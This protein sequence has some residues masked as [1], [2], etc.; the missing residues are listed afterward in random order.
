MPSQFVLELA[1]ARSALGFGEAG[2]PGKHQDGCRVV[3]R[4]GRALAT[5]V[6]NAGTN[7]GAYLTALFGPGSLNHLG[8]RWAFVNNWRRLGFAW[9]IL[10]LLFVPVSGR[11][12]RDARSRARLYPKRSSTRSWANPVVAA[13]F[14]TGK[15]GRSLAENSDRSDNGGSICFGSLIFSSGSTACGSWQIGVP[16]WL[17]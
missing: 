16:I 11:A 3:P 1:I 14:R 15:P 2:V 17:I 8:W 12:P 6:F 10:W 7:V 9:M 5:G 4:K 13:L